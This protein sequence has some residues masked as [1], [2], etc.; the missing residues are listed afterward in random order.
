MISMLLSFA[1][2]HAASSEKGLP[3]KVQLTLEVA[4]K[5]AAASENYAKGKKVPCV[6]AI[7]DDTGYPLLVERMEGVMLASA[8]LAPEKAK[9]AVLFKRN[10]ADLEKTVNEGRTAM[11]TAAHLVL[12]QGG[13][14]IN[15]DGKTIGAIATSCD[16]K[17]QDLPVAQA[18]LEAFKP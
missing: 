17:D 5:M 6:I 14:V 11:V 2:A 3:T 13:L 16:V 7:A 12:M 15:Q 9:S 4:K 18:G 8:I 10:S 1:I